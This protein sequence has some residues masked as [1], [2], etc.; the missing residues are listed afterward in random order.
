VDPP[1]SAP[2]DAATVLRAV[3][4]TATVAG[5]F[6]EPLAE[7]A[8]REGKPLPS[9]RDRYTPFRFYPLREHASLL[10]EACARLYPNLPLRQALRKLGRGA[11]QALLT[12]TLGKVVLASAVGPDEIIAAMVKAYPIN[13][14]PSR[15]QIVELAAGRAIVRV[16]EMHYFLD[17]HHIG[18]FEGVI[19]Y[20]G[21]RGTV[22]ICSYSPVSADLLCTW[23]A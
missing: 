17:S 20:A 22:K 21:R 2:L 6:L 15:L 7:A 11:P 1:W 23:T 3:P 9:A 5:L 18:A 14:R 10:I 8:R 16:E 12:S 4:E 13:V 19:S